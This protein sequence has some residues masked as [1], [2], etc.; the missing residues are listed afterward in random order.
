MVGFAPMINLI[1][2]NTNHAFVPFRLL[3]IGYH[4]TCQR[5][6]NGSFTVARGGIITHDDGRYPRHH[7]IRFQDQL[8]RHSTKR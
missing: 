5:R 7:A 3:G 1:Y 8:E 4:S 6:G 2:S